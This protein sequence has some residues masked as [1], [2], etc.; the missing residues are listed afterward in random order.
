MKL[1]VKKLKISKLQQRVSR[2][3]KVFNPLNFIDYN[4]TLPC[5]EIELNGKITYIYY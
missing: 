2:L 5:Q 4:Y 1:K 3:E